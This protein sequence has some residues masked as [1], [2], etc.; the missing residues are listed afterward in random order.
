MN[1]NGFGRWGQVIL[2]HV[3]SADAGEAGRLLSLRPVAE[4][5]LPDRS[6]FTWKRWTA[7]R[8][9]DEDIVLEL[10]AVLGTNAAALD[11]EIDW[12]ASS[13]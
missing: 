3:P 11:W 2:V 13:Y 5:Y 8:G 12:A 10:S 6:A 1:A 9:D 4:N 7:R